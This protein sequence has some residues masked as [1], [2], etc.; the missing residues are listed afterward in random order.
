MYSWG[1]VGTVLNALGYEDTLRAV[2]EELVPVVGETFEV[3]K[4]SR[5]DLEP[6]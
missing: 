5:P 4:N 6:W 3:Y 1:F 2:C